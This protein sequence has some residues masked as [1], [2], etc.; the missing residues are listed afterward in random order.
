MVF[1]GLDDVEIAAP[2]PGAQSAS[3]A[4]PK[5]YVFYELKD[6][7]KMEAVT[8]GITRHLIDNI[9]QMVLE[10][11]KISAQ[12]ALQS[13]QPAAVEQPAEEKPPLKLNTVDYGGVNI[14]NIDIADF[15]MDFIKSKYCILDKYLVLSLSLE[16]TRKVI[17]T[18]KNNKNSLAS[19]LSFTSVQKESF[20]DYSNIF[21][22]DFEK[23]LN[24][25]HYSK[26]FNKF[27]GS[28]AQDKKSKFSK[29]DVDSLFK[30]LGSINTFVF[31]DRMV[32]SE[33]LESVYY[34]KVKGL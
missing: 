4:F 12:R 10:Q 6:S 15:P 20:A 7:K 25:V 27:I 33:T 17:D 31:T 3:L 34:L 18:Y 24:G 23:L 21:F 29:D 1:A 22:F 30:L 11:K 26:A 14:Y 28:L 8:G 5:F 16:L 32:D 2:S 9:N 19:N 13:A